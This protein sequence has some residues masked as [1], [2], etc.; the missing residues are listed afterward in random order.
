MRYFAG[1]YFLLITCLA[2]NNPYQ[3]PGH[4]NFVADSAAKHIL[5]P[6]PVTPGSTVH[7]TTGKITPAELLA[8]AGTLKGIPYKYGSVDPREG[9]DCSG[10]I[11]YVFNHFNIMV[12]R[13]SI[14]FTD[15]E[16][17]IPLIEAKPGDLVLF[18][19]TD[20]TIRKV[21][22]MGIMV[23]PA[24]QPPEFIHATSGKA[25]G[26]TITP[27]NTYYMGRYMKMIRI[28]PQNDLHH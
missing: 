8:F 19:G 15:V 13:M 11:T 20:S 28:F 16:R 1:C 17:E 18:T 27:L 14:E 9:F 6:L 23:S 26:V 10:F 4:K 25:K 2:C 3:Q 7:I 22:H 24:G 12:P 5:P 21:G